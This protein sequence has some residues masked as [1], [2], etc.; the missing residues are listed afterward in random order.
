MAEILGIGTTDYPRLRA[1]DG[2]MAAPFKGTLQSRPSE[3]TDPKSWPKPMQEEWG[4]DEGLTAGQGAREKAVI[5][6]RKLKAA[7]DDFKPDL[8]LAWAKDNRESLKGVSIPQWWIQAN[9]QFETKIFT[10]F[11]SGESYFGQ[12]LTDKTVTVPG[13][14]EGAL[15]LARGLQSEGFD[16]TYS[17]ESM[18]P[19][20]LAHTFGGVFTHLDWDKHEYATP[21]IPVSVDMFGFMRV[22]TAAGL[23]DWDESM[24]TPISPKRAFELGR[25]TARVFKASPWRVALVAGTS[26]S[27]TNNTASSRNWVHPDHANDVKRHTEWANNQFD[28]WGDNWTFKEM[29]EYGQWE[30]LCWIMLAGAMTEIGAKIVHSDIQLN[31]VF[32]DNWVNTIFS[33]A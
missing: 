28:K 3:A 2:W 22:R 1:A 12:G 19:N 10:P 15:Y 9:E 20:G 4:D 24:P 29:E 21:V 14:Q 33:V 5:Q 7:L 32:N 13:H 8:I 25:A 27:H 11:V 6:F 30:L 26:W 16:P 31:W 18:A 23:T 17:V